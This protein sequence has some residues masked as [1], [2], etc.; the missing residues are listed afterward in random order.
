ML[1]QASNRVCEG[2]MRQNA[3]QGKF[4]LNEADYLRMITEKTAELCGVGC[5][6]GAFLSSATSED[7]E[8]F[9]SYGIN[10]GVAFQIIDAVLDIV[11][12][13][14]NVGK[15][16]GTDLVN[17]KPTLPVI[18]ALATL[19]GEERAAFVEFFGTPKGDAEALNRQLLETLGRCGSIEY[20]RNIARDHAGQ[21]ID[22]AQSQA[23]SAYSDA[24]V[25]LA[26]FVL[27]RT[28]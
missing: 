4:E 1:A 23:K 19:S 6:L 8:G 13:P 21:A 22:F 12:T 10:L 17:Q 16:L 7:V 18:H 14:D 5:R 26:Q 2:E 9:A 27:S 11:G 28:H 24:L 15:T 3:W 20:A 25:A